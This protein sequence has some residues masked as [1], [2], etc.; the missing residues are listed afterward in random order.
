MPSKFRLYKQV[1]LMF[2]F[3]KGHI[4]NL[5]CCHCPSNS[6]WRLDGRLPRVLVW[7]SMS[8]SV[9]RISKNVSRTYTQNVR[10]GQIPFR[11]R[12]FFPYWQVRVL[13]QYHI[14]PHTFEE[15]AFDLGFQAY[16]ESHTNTYTCRN[17]LCVDT[18][19]ARE[20]LDFC[21]K[22][23]RTNKYRKCSVQ[24]TWP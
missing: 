11:F 9:N 4:T 23:R 10:S 20:K 2:G 21:V 17:E 5:C 18:F 16:F 15:I 6:C 1:K 3:P 22:V 12:N 7:I 19:L 24:K 8:I 13:C 14:F